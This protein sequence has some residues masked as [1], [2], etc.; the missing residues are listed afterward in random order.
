MPGC[1]DPDIPRREAYF[2]A[3]VD[4]RGMRKTQ[5]MGFFSTAR[6]NTQRRIVMKVILKEDVETLG[7]R[8]DTI[9]VT[10]GY[11]RNY[12]IPKGFAMEATSISVKAIEHEKK[13]LAKRA[14]KDKKNAE[15]MLASFAGVA[16]TIA[17]KTADQEKL[18]GSVTTKD[19]EKA[20]EEKGLTVER[21]Q[22]GLDEPIKQ[23]GEY[24]VK[25]KLYPGIAADITVKVVEEQG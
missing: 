1:K 18:F 8:G 20:L 24:P 2:A 7:K 15:A 5:Q 17:R 11:A 16:V 4:R 19:I 13:L 22:I 10:D 23:L 25:I 14:E 6:Q 9:K 21:K 12:L 3:Y